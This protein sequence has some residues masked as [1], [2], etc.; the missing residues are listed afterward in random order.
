MMHIFGMT[1]PTPSLVSMDDGTVAVL[2][3]QIAAAAAALQDDPP[4]ALS[5]SVRRDTKR[6]L[7]A[8][9]KGELRMPKGATARTCDEGALVLMRLTVDA[10]AVSAKPELLVA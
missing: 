3:G 6:Y 1:L 4:A 7:E 8:R 2:A 10:P 5:M 9:R